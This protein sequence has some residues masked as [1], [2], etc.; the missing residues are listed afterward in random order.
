MQIWQTLAFILAMLI[1]P[2]SICEQPTDNISKCMPD[3]AKDC[4]KEMGQQDLTQM[5][6]CCHPQA[7]AVNVSSAKQDV[8]QQQ[9]FFTP[10]AYLQTPSGISFYYPS[11]STNRLDTHP[12][13]QLAKIS[14]LRI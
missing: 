10:V 7:T 2:I 3:C 4:G 5:I 14:I 1:A 6:S 9:T 11:A 8:R 12:G 13:K